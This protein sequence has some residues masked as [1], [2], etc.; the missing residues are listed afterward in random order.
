[1]NTTLLDLESHADLGPTYVAKLL[2]VA[3]PT[4]AQCRSGRRP[5]Q[6]YH[7]RHVQA[8]ILLPRATLLSLIE[9]HV[10]GRR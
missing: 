8:L 4:Y 6:A 7:E 5:L 3:Y 10:Y 9:E 2:G 1:M